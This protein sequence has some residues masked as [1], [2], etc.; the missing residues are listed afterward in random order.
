MF[1][2]RCI[3]IDDTRKPK[4]IPS[5]KWVKIGNIYHITHI[6]KQ[7]NQPGLKGVELAE[8]D[9]SMCSPYNSYRLSR[10]AIHEDDLQKFIELCKMTNELNNIDIQNFV[11]ELIEKGDLILQD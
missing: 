7:I 9:I 3:C 8:F 11:E 1:G 10:F 2:I 4:E 6:Y 5:D